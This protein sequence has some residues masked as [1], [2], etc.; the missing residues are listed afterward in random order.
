MK[1]D[2]EM[3]HVVQPATDEQI[4]EWERLSNAATPG[5]WAIWRGHTYEGGGE[6]IC[7]GAGETW[8]ANM[9]HRRPRC[10][11]IAEDGHSMDECDICTVDAPRITDEQVANG[12]LIAAS[13]VA[14]PALIARIKDLD[15]SIMP[16][17]SNGKRLRSKMTTSLD[18]GSLVIRIPIDLLVWA[19]EHRESGGLIVTNKKA[20]AFYLKNRI[21]YSQ[22]DAET[23]STAIER[24]IDDCFDEAYED[25]EGWLKELEAD[26]K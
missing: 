19:Q 24:L 22:L 15:A 9:D 21:L 8:L 17:H 1:G 20:M 16:S 18:G 7:I 3:T 26:E 6:D 10:P 23:S 4:A 12:N 2:D 25:G 14:I 5:P 13:R 11:Q